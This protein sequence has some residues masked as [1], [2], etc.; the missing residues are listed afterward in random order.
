M[1][2]LQKKKIFK[3]VILQ[4]LLLLTKFSKLTL[5]TGRKVKGIVN[6]VPADKNMGCG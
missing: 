3:E 2:D 4:W 1:Y 6:E 5:S